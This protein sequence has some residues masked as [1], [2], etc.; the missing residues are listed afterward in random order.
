MR[1]NYESKSGLALHLHPQS[2]EHLR[3]F[4]THLH[5][6]QVRLQE[7]LISS[8]HALE[9]SGIVIHTGIQ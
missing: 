3:L 6:V 4:L 9:T 5:L 7:H 8:L 1:V 2:G